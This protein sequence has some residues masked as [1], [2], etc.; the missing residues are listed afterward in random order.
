MAKK[1]VIHIFH[2]DPDAIATGSR[3]AQRML[4]I[5]AENGVEVE[6]FCFGPAQR[7]LGTTGTDAESTFNRQID[8]LIAAGVVVGA[9]VNAARAENS[10]DAL[11]DRG[12]NLQVARDEFM[13]FALDDATIITF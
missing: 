12:F 5:A 7:K 9:C 8:E 2:D 10:E 6:V 4:E 11:R 3:V 13:R 1:T